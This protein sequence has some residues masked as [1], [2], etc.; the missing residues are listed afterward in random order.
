MDAVAKERATRTYLSRVS[1]SDLPVNMHMVYAPI[2]R[3]EADVNVISRK[4]V[5]DSIRGISES[6]FGFRK[7]RELLIADDDHYHSEG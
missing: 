2:I 6:Q 7:A 5:R 1:L 4:V 3:V